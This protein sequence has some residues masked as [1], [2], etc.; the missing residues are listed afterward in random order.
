M[1]LS[2]FLA[3]AAEPLTLQDARR[4]CLIADSVTDQDPYLEDLIPVVRERAEQATDRA[5][6]PQTW[7]WVLD[8]FPVEDYLE[9]PKPPLRTVTWVKYQDMA[10]AWQ[11]WDPAN[12]LVE[13]PAGPRGLRGRLSLPFAGTWPV[14]LP[15]AG[16]VSIRFEAGYADA[17]HVPALLKQAM[18]LDLGTFYLNRESVLTNA[19]EQAI[20]LP[21][22]SREIYATFRAPATQRLRQ[23]GAW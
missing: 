8:G 7:D 18:R 23:G 14:V 12:Y 21:H 10:G 4:Q 15:Q 2:L 9:I 17:A 22:G 3:P 6:L 13:A 1:S 16:C 11:T 19:R 20:E 5:L